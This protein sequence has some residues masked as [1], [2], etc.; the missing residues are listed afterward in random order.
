MTLSS[1]QIKLVIGLF[2]EGDFN[3]ALEYSKSLSKYHPK[4]PLLFNVNGACYAGLR[5]F[6]LSIEA[7]QKSI[8]LDFLYYKAHYN[9]AGVFHEICN[10]DAAIDSYKR[11]LS[12]ES[13]Y[14][15]AHNNLGNVYRDINELDNAIDS[16]KNAI[17]IKSDYFEAIY[18]LGL[19]FQD[20][21]KIEEAINK[22]NIA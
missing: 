16:Y 9:L 3:G 22:F 10:Y 11:A 17:E 8:E 2:N 12:I 6:E 5:Q 13:N 14:A 18:S 4:E 7:Y 19:S 1:E 15:E 21:N 20:Q